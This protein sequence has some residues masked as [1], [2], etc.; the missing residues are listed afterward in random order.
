[1]E[2]SMSTGEE[3]VKKIKPLGCAA[4]IL[5][6]VAVVLT[7]FTTKGIAVDGYTPPHGS[8]YYSD[9]LD[10]LAEELS[11]T[12]LPMIDATADFEVGE[13]VITIT[14]ST[15]DLNNLRPRIL[16][17]YDVDLFEF[18]YSD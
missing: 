10:E 18:V 12:L 11:G 17:Y 2:M 9:H 3:F 15:D 1:M 16:H 4:F 14:A 8:D 13:K 7:C 5:L 6:T